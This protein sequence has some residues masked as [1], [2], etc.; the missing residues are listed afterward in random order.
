VVGG[1]LSAMLCALCGR[2]YRT[3]LLLF[4]LLLIFVPLTSRARA[5]DNGV[6]PVQL[7]HTADG[8]GWEL[9]RAGKPFFIQGAGGSRSL[10]L[11]VDC[12]G[13]SIRTWGADEGLQRQL[14][15]AQRLGLTVT[16]GIWLGHER[17]GFNYADSKQVAD[18]FEK[19]RLA[20]QRYKD[21]PALLMWGIGNEME[22]YEKGDNPSIWKAVNDIAAMAKQLDSNHP[23][24]TVIAEIGGERVPCINRLCPAIDVIGVNS[25]G[26]GP[27]LAKRYRE[28]GG[29]KPFVFTEF[30][31]PGMWE[32]PKT[33]W[34]APIE[35]TSTAKAD[36]YRK[37]YDAS[38]LS[39]KGKLCL[40][41]Y[42]FLWG[43]KQE[44]T[45]TWFGMLL[46]DGSRTAA[47]DT[48]A[49]LWSG[50]APSNRCPRIESLEIAGSD[51][52]TAGATIHASVKA[53]DP[54]KE[55]L[56]VEWQLHREA[57]EHA[58]GGDRQPVPPT[59]PDA[60]V[61]GDAHGAE[62]KLPSEPGGYRL[63][64][65]IRDAHGGAA[66]ANVPLHVR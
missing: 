1:V 64:V 24:M 33:S 36:F 39:E 31:P 54:E 23:T 52:V 42:V 58:T 32:S 9:L 46:P 47:V 43:S 65:F 29:S 45:A 62:I 16:I 14:D 15:E 30:G 28:A 41:S 3:S 57:E 56:R 21:H 2:R 49:E 44:A 50:H 66:V 27:T 60:I 10:Q 5:G 19:C 6:V 26:G 53:S 55:E 63:F 40:G 22:G 38:V 20:I 59:Y 8:A 12:G 48:L 18:Q 37:S 25:Y 61:R 34:G 13:N 4:L 35:P 51:E 7:R 11:L 17:H